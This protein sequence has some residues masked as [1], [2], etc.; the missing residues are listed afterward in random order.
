MMVGHPAP[1]VDN[2]VL[3]DAKKRLEPNDDGA[4]AHRFTTVGQPATALVEVLGQ[5]HTLRFISA[6]IYSCSTPANQRS[7]DADNHASAAASAAA[8]ASR[9]LR[10]WRFLYHG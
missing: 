3:M 1:N 6:L 5:V 2:R 4:F 10:F 9:F 8:L 7:G